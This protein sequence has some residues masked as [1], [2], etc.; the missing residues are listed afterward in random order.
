MLRSTPFMSLEDILEEHTAR[1]NTLR[2]EVN[3]SEDI[4]HKKQLQKLLSK[5]NEKQAENTYAD[6]R[7]ASQKQKIIYDD[8]MSKIKAVSNTKLV[9][10]IV[11]VSV[12][13]CLGHQKESKVPEF[14]S[15]E[16]L[17]D[18]SPKINTLRR[19]LERLSNAFGF[20]SFEVKYDSRL[21]VFL[22]HYHIIILGA[23]E[24]EVKD[25][26]YSLYPKTYSFRIDFA[27]LK[28][29]KPNNKL[30]E[31][32]PQKLKIVDIQTIKSLNDDCT[33]VDDNTQNIASYICKFK[34]YQT[35]YYQ[36]GLKLK[37]YKNNPYCRPIDHIHNL[38]LLFLDKLKPSEHFTLFNKDLMMKVITQSTH[39]TVNCDV[40][41]PDNSQQQRSNV[42]KCAEHNTYKKP[43]KTSDEV[44][45]YFGYEKYK[46]SEQRRI[47]K[48][49]KKHYSCLIIQ[50]TSFGKS[51][52]Y[53]AV[54]MQMKGLCV[55]IEPIKPL[56]FDQCHSLNKIKKGLAITINSD[57]TSKHVRYLCKLKQKKYKFLFV[58]PEMLENKNLQ[59]ALQQL[60]ISLFVI[61][62]A[63]CIDFWG[64]DFR[65]KYDELQKYIKLFGP[66]KLM[67][68]TA[69]AD[70]I[71]QRR[72]KEV[73]NC[74]D[75]KIFRGE[76]DRP[77]IQYEIQ[78]KED[79]GIEQLIK[80][81]QPYLLNNKPRETIIIYC[82]HRDY[83]LAVH[84]ALADYGIK[85]L[86]CTGQT[87]NKRKILKNFLK[88]NTIVVAT[89]AFG[90]GIDKSDVRLVVHFEVPLNLEFYSQESGRAGRDG[91]PAKS[92]IIYSGY[93][94]ISAERE[95]CK[96]KEQKR[97]FEKVKIYLN[98]P[99]SKRREFLL[100]SIC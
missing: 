90:M 8:I 16:N 70:K 79:D 15:R 20:I 72:I 31:F 66:S 95:F 51:F 12:N 92:I 13:S 48:F 94:I 30:I 43:L 100:K 46:N 84:T 91:K 54:A 77:N 25:L 29:D 97:K 56:M 53:Q 37:V 62:E 59:E 22:P 11:F 7:Y 6:I 3:S 40:C 34:T 86:M 35:N 81:L 42:S 27:N 98:L 36:K 18:Y 44:L 76:L 74:F 88:H 41:E 96:T 93:D 32:M 65:P 33:N 21:N 2:R 9:N 49:M 55:V 38:H 50:P 68:L 1:K 39:K 26:F 71:T 24:S 82:N 80:I 63:H 85:S 45:E 28:I 83:V 78:L 14:I 99:P 58:S 69:T 23:K 64:G 47:I 17:L 61:D 5:F 67:L 4:I 75:I 60:D 52:C 73:C 87:K 19:Q 57:N 10:D 89:N